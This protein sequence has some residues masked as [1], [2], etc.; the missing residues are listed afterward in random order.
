MHID[1]LE[2]NDYVDGVLA[3][4]DAQRV[5]AH[6]AECEACAQEI[7][8]ISSLR[9][10]LSALPHEIAPAR[11]LR[12]GMWE[13]IDASVVTPIPAYTHTP[14]HA[15]TPRR[16]AAAAVLLIAASS[17]IT[18]MILHRD[19]PAQFAE[20]RSTG[21]RTL[22]SARSVELRYNGEV[23]ELQAVLA[24]SRGRLA[25]ETVRILTDNLAIIDKAIGEAKAALAADPNSDML[26]DLLR[27][28]YERKVDLLRQAA[29]SSPTT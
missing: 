7:A 17:A 19:Q 29:K 4:A 1:D 21:S 28:A 3:D 16:L 12:A 2:L 20:P 27:S 24:K 5:A 15:Y 18:V 11:D 22:V 10:N 14:I 6:I 23:E 13:K 9:A 25:P 8:Q 26:I